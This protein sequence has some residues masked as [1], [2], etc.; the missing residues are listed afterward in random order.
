MQLKIIHVKQK[1]SI[2]GL[3]NDQFDEQGIPKIIM[4]D[5]KNDTYQNLKEIVMKEFFGE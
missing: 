3:Q 4:V 2:D 1:E 5:R